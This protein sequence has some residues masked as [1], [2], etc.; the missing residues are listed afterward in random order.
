[1]Q[2]CVFCELL[3][4]PA[5]SEGRR[6]YEDDLVWV[7]H[8]AEAAGTSYR[9]AAVIVLKRRTEAGLADLRDEEGE[10]IGRLVARLSRAFRTQLGAAWTY[11]YCFTE[12]YRHVHQFVR[13]RY[14]GVPPEHVRLGLADWAEAPRATPEEIRVLSE[15]LRRSLDRSIRSTP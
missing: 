15:R 7:A 1:M 12:G 6:L 3:E 10:R 9:G 4:D 14:P 11:T 5:R 13:A 8:E 2:R